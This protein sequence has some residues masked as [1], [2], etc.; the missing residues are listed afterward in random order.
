M[1]KLLVE[2][3]GGMMERERGWGRAYGL[4]LRAGQQIEQREK[5]K[6]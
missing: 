6:K 5:Y 2:L 1:N 3:M 4:S